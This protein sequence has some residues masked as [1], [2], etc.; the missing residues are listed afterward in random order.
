M[1][2][3]SLPVWICL[4]GLQVACAPPFSTRRSGMSDD[5]SEDE[6]T[7]SDESGGDGDTLGD[8]SADDGD[9]EPEPERDAGGTD[10][11]DD[12]DDGVVPSEPCDFAHTRDDVV[13]DTGELGE[14]LSNAEPG[15]LIALADGAY[16]GSFRLEGSGTASAPIILCGSANA[17]LEGNDDGKNTLTLAGNHWVLSGF[18]VTGGMRGVV[19]DQASDNQLVGLSVHD[20]GQEAIHLLNHSARNTVQR[21]TVRDTGLSKPGFGEGI[22]VGSARDNWLKVT[23]TD[24]PDRSDDNRLL[25]NELGPGVRAEHIDIKEGT[26]GGLVRGNTF[27]G[28]G[29]SGENYADSWMDVK[30]ND[31]LI[32]DNVGTDT[33]ADG[34]QTHVVDDE[35]GHDIV[36]RGNTANV[37]ASGYGF[38]VGGGSSGVVVECS[39]EVNGAGEGFA[40]VSCA[41]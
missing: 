7:A 11:D 1:Q 40:N 13:N 17:V 25:D 3:R 31:Y 19:L 26:S 32:E 6:S 41:L 33:L 39:N 29:L 2:H 5:S 36:F 18:S 35:W 16:R 23:G 21:C 24:A 30:G 8:D 12:D 10:A 38:S 9:S 4:I 22:Y 20:V 27:H 34:F 28:D 14:A 15:S 37:N